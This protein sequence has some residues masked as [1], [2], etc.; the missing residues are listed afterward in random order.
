[1]P[2]RPTIPPDVWRRL[3]IGC[4]DQDEVRRVLA[5]YRAGWAGGQSSITEAIHVAVMGAIA[6]PDV[7][8]LETED[9]A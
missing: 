8:A 5:G 7:A 9:A 1:M 4:R 3:T 2:D 6:T